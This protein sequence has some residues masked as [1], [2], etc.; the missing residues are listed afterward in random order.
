MLR[1]L[2]D[3]QAQVVVEDE[4]RSLLRRKPPEPAFELVPIIDSHEGV[5]RVRG[6]RRDDDERRLPTTLLRLGVASVDEDAVQPRLEAV[7]AAKGG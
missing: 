5:G 7:E 1:H 3:W 6:L 2:R 4:D